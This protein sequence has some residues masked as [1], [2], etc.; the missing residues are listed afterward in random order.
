MS[1][2]IIFIFHE[3]LI[4]RRTC[5]VRPLSP[6]GTASSSLASSA[7]RQLRITKKSVGVLA[8]HA[9]EMLADMRGLCRRVGQRD[10]LVER[11]ARFVRTAEL[12]QKCALGAEEVELAG[13]PVRQ[14]FDQR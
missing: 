4:C 9:V 14:R 8:R 6:T 7:R 10:R 12:Q 2:L 5:I 3:P 11:D 1:N 13:Q